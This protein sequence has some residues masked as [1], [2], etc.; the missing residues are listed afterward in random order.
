MATVD[1]D[2][3]RYVD[4][5]KNPGGGHEARGGFGDYAFSGDLRVLRRLDRL[6]PVRIVVESTVRF[7]KNFRRMSCSAPR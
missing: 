3:Q 5:K 4:K 2:F 6:A 1:F 7:W